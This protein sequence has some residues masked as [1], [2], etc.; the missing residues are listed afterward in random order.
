MISTL[1]QLTFPNSKIY[2]GQSRHF[3]SRMNA[4][5]SKSLNKKSNTY[6]LPIG[7]AIRKYGWDNVQKEIILSCLTKDVDYFESYLIKLWK[8]QDKKFGYNCESGGNKYKTHSTETK[9]KMSKVKI[10]RIFS[11]EHRDNIA[12]AI[13]NGYK[14]GTRPKPQPMLG[15]TGKN[16]PKSQPVCQVDALTGSILKE[17]ASAREVE[18]ELKINHSRIHLVCLNKEHCKT[19]GGFKWEYKIKANNAKSN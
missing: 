10:G 16:N 7:R 19:A 6:N 11:S 5:K 12:L 15:R 9:E 14:D 8:T 17:W 1:Y 2:I 18:R 3:R 4:Y 13:R